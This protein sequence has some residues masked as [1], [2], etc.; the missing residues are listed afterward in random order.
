MKERS[1]EREE[2]NKKRQEYSKKRRDVIWGK[3]KK[4]EK[5]EAKNG[6]KDMMKGERWAEVKTGKGRYCRE[7]ERKKKKTNRMEK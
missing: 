3:G 5:E 6:R 2:K 4:W 1:N 7:R